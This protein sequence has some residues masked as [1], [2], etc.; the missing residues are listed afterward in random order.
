MKT[1]MG[2]LSL[3][4]KLRMDFDMDWKAIL[5]ADIR[6]EAQYNAASLEHRRSWHNSQKTAYHRRLKALQ[7]QHSVDLT[8]VK[9][10]V[11]KEMKGYQDMRA[12]HGRQASRLK[13]CIV[14]GKTECNDYYS[15]ELERDNR[16]KQKLITTPT[17]KLDPYV[18][19]S[20]EVYNNL[21][22]NQKSKYH[23]SMAGY[24][25]DSNFHSRMLDR[26]KNDTPL[27]TFPS[28]KYGGE[29]T[30]DFGKEYTK[31]E[32]LSMDKDS[33]IKY[34]STM[35]SRFKRKGNSELGKYHWKMRRRIAENS[36]LPTYFSPEHEQEGD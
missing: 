24:G 31:E 2:F 11:Y 14:L 26:I 7:N 3:P 17:G 1:T 36:N 25:K 27:P 29:P 8:D 5:K 33:K 4:S 16:R 35:S 21:T 19:L 13:N 10:P 9:N 12:F 34:H 20:L 28:P 30:K 18:E 6:N 32:Y 23:A 15:L 22:N